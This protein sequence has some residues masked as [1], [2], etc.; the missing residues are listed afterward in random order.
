MRRGGED[1]EF[2]G[3]EGLRHVRDSVRRS[4][5]DDEVDLVLEQPLPEC[6]TVGYFQTNRDSRM[7]LPKQTEDGRKDVGTRRADRG[8]ADSS[9]F[10]SLQFLHDQPGVDAALVHPFR[11]R[12][13]GAAR[14]G[15]GHLAARAL[16]KWRADRLLQFA[17]LDRNPGL[18]EVELLGR[19]RITETPMDG[20][21]DSKLMQRHKRRIINSYAFANFF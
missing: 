15:Q 5:H 2:F 16:E 20:E 6:G 10:Q 9:P 7:R 8:K 1:D 11:V 18:A 19:P 14:I 21:K 3:K 12:E 17:H 13:Q 4:P